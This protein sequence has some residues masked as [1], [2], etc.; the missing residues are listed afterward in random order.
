MHSRQRAWMPE[1]RLLLSRLLA[2]ILLGLVVACGGGDRDG[3]SEPGGTYTVQRGDTVYSIATRHGIAPDALIAANNLRAPYTILVGDQLRIP[4]PRSYVVTEGDTLS[5]I[6]LRSRVD[7]QTLA[8]VNGLSPP[9]TIYSGQILML[10]QPGRRV[11]SVSATPTRRA[12]PSA[13]SSSS[14]GQTTASR[15]SSSRQA[16][17]SRST[18]PAAAASRSA[19]A[20]APQ[21]IWP[22]RGK[23]VSTFGAKADGNYN[24]GVNIAVAA[25]TPVKAAAGGVVAYAGNELRGFGNLVLLRHAGGYMTAYGHNSAILVSRDEKVSQGQE[26]AKVGATGSVSSPQLHFEVRKGTKALNPVTV[27]GAP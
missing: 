13:S 26:I 4:G 12:T 7:M 1:P 24:D 9:Y 2:L 23:I 16:S 27:L 10:P 25:G 17:A 11:A 8:A 20:S 19:S 18:P 5:E 22:V 3:L 21:F 6:A 14:R 15:A